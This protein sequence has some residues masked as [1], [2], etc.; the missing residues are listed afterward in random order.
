MDHDIKE[1]AERVDDNVALATTDFLASVVAAVNSRTSGFDALT[2]DD[3]SVLGLAARP[4]RSRSRRV[5]VRLSWRQ[6]PSFFH[7]R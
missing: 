5:N 6:V 4:C 7:L 3:P 1:I 2:V